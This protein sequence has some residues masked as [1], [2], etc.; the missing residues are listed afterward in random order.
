MRFIFNILAVAAFACLG[1]S[2]YSVI[3]GS[4]N[5]PAY[6]AEVSSKGTPV[7]EISGPVVPAEAQAAFAS[8]EKRFKQN[9]SSCHKLQ[10]NLVGPAL[11]GVNEKYA[12]DPEW[13]Y[14]W[15]KN[16]SKLVKEGDEKAL[17]IWN[18]Y[19]QAAMTAFPQLTDDQ[20]GEI[21]TYI[22]YGV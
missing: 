1:F 13:L 5:A 14:A 16:S 8:G 19:N 17:K 7:V 22:E 11:A 15:I 10:G 18:E 9:C 3:K 4:M 12:A 2:F 21:L 20:I 6:T